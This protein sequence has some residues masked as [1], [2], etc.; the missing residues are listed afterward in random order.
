M[1]RTGVKV[2]AVGRSPALSWR[3]AGG[4]GT[5]PRWQEA[6]RQHV[7]VGGWWARKLGTHFPL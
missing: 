5:P 6:N 3:G 2:A 4:M 1:Q 7:G